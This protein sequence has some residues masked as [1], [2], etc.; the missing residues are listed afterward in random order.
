MSIQNDVFG[1]LGEAAKEYV[2]AVKNVS[3]ARLYDKASAKGAGATASPSGSVNSQP[4]NPRPG[5]QGAY[6]QAEGKNFFGNGFSSA[7]GTWFI[8]GAL[9]LLLL[10]LARR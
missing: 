4:Y 2:N 8:A 5:T 6:P 3:L 10:F 1:T 9:V 7:G